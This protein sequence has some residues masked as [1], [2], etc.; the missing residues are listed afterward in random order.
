MED[1]ELTDRRISE[2]KKA[3][4]IVVVYRDALSNF[5]KSLPPG[6][7]I[8]SY[9]RSNDGQYDGPGVKVPGSNEEYIPLPSDLK[10]AFTDFYS[11]R[12]FLQSALK[13]TLSPALYNIQDTLLFP[14]IYDLLNELAD[15]ED[16]ET[17][18]KRQR[19]NSITLKIENEDVEL[20]KTEALCLMALK[21]TIVKKKP[22]YIRSLYI[23]AKVWPEK[24]IE[25]KNKFRFAWSCLRKK[26]GNKR[27]PGFQHIPDRH[28]G[29]CLGT[30]EASWKP[31]AWIRKIRFPKDLILPFLVKANR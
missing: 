25:S 29:H 17:P 14:Y 10:K 7:K 16:K 22:E 18:K 2:L 24:A 21:E 19:R 13:K 5:I 6:G 8:T 28:I 23:T 9:L 3:K 12:F 27:L 15:V 1:A 30:R 20:T 26:L 31:P 4:E 11:Q